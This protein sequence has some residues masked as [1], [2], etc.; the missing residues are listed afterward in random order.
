MSVS[1]LVLRRYTGLKALSERGSA[2]SLGAAV[3]VGLSLRK[4][5][6]FDESEGYC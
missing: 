3:M 5:D 6:I 2:G 4:L 1:E